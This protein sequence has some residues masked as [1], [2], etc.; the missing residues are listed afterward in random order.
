MPHSLLN[1]FKLWRRNE[2]EDEEEQED[3]DEEDEE[4]L[5][6]GFE[7]NEFEGGKLARD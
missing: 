1:S 7:T 4:R 3:D 5:N 2:E 6:C